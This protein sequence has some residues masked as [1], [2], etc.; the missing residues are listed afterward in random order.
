MNNY[1][2]LFYKTT[3]MAHGKNLLWHVTER[4]DS[5]SEAL[6]KAERQ[7]APGLEADCIEVKHIVDHA[8]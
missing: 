7:L 5:P 6:V 2:V 4:G 8:P 1:L 3:P